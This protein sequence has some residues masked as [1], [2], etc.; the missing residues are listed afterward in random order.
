[1]APH[2]HTVSIRLGVS[3][4]AWCNGYFTCEE[5]TPSTHWI[6]GRWR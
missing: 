6:W 5:Q 1:M 2:A 3:G 4:L